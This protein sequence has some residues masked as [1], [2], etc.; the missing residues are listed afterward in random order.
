VSI[1]P[2]LRKHAKGGNGGEKKTTVSETGDGEMGA[3]ESVAA[4][5]GAMDLNAGA[6]AET[7]PDAAQ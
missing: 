4:R 6:G 2:L 5:V 3:A 1:S 7:K